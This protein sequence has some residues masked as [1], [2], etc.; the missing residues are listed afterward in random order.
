MADCSKAALIVIDHQLGT[1]DPNFWGNAQSNPSYSENLQSLLA[2]FRAFKDGPL[3]PHVIHVYHRSINPHSPLYPGNPTMNIRE[4]AAPL[5]SEPVFS[6]STNSAFVKPE[7]GAYLKEKDIRRIYFVG[8]SIDMC[9]GSTIRH[10]SDLAIG[11][12]VNGEEESVRGDIVLI[13]DAVA[14]WAKHGG[15]YDAETVHGVHVESLRGEFAR[16]VTTVEALKE[17]RI[18]G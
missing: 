6:K 14:A 16:V 7:L 13:E 15:S 2:A 5:P 12:Y 17:L 18:G 11:S 4:D 3:A 9:V 8:L 1:F 10:A